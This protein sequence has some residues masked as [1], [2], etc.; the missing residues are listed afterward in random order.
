MTAPVVGEFGWSCGMKVGG[1]IWDGVMKGLIPEGMSYRDGEWST[2]GA[3]G[4]TQPGMAV[5]LVGE[6]D[7]CGQ[8]H[9]LKPVL[10]ILV[11]SG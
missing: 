10:H 11:D 9:R 6:F 8:S 1:W 5:P 2:S 7:W 3:G 4:S